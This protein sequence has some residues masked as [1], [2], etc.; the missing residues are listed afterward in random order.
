MGGGIRLG[1]LD[2]LGPS[3]GLAARHHGA[4]VG[5]GRPAE[6]AERLGDTRFAPLIRAHLELFSSVATAFRVR[7]MAFRTEQ[8]YM[9]WMCRFILHRGGQSPS[10]LGAAEV[11]G[12]LQYLAVERNVAASTQTRALNALVVLYDRECV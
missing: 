3:G 11:A 5:A 9:H 6:F 7:N 12:F 10:H 1:F 8:T 4:G 2:C